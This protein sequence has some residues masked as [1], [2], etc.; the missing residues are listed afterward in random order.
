MAKRD[1]DARGGLYLFYT[2]AAIMCFIIGFGVFFVLKQTT[3]GILIGVIGSFAVACALDDY[4]LI[5]MGGR[6]NMV[7]NAVKSLLARAT[8]SAA[9]FAIAD[10]YK[11]VEQIKAAYRKHRIENAQVIVA[12]DF[13]ESNDEQGSKTF[14]GRSLHD[15]TTTD[16]NPYEQA[17]MAMERTLSKLDSDNKI[18]FLVFGDAECSSKKTKQIPDKG[19][20]LDGFCGVLEYYRAYAPTMK[21]G[22]PTNFAPVID[23]AVQINQD[24]GGHHILFILTDGQVVNKRDTERAIVQ[25]SSHALSIVVIGVGDGPFDTMNDYDDGLTERRFDNLQFVQWK[26]HT[27]RGKLADNE[28]MVAAMQELPAQIKA[29]KEL[30]LL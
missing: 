27:A 18:P 4:E 19:V 5:K 22:G 14:D 15:L 28:F 17:L 29:I 24:E 12:I 26:A 11:S 16:G 3:M 25:A 20:L 13:T 9:S 6:G 23:Y 7:R 8:S 2:W 30:R 21:L 1:A 10:K